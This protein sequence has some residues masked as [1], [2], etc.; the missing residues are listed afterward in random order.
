MPFL[1][2]LA[3]IAVSGRHVGDMSATFPAKAA[4]KSLTSALRK[5]GK[6][7][8]LFVPK[9]EERRILCSQV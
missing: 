9:R 4:R 8:G 3:N 5:F 2:K 7:N 6:P 1:E